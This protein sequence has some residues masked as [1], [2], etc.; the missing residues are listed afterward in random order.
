MKKKN[1]RTVL[2]VE[3]D[4]GEARWLLVAAGTK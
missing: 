1:I 4:P 2:L 3:D